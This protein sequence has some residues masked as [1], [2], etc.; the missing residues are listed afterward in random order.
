MNLLDKSAIKA[1]VEEI[2]AILPPGF[3]ITYIEDKD[4]DGN[5]TGFDRVEINYK[6]NHKGEIYINSFYESHNFPGFNLTEII[7]D[8]AEAFWEKSSDRYY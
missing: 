2:R 1:K 6:D 5:E 4:K 3:T 7:G 8:I